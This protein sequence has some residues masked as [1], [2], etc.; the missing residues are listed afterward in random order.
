MRARGWLV[1]ALLLPSLASAQ[2][3]N[4][5]AL[6]ISGPAELV[7]GQSYT[8]EATVRASGPASV[9]WMVYLTQGGVL[10]G[11]VA[12]GPL[13]PSAVS[14]GT[15]TV[16]GQATVP[17]GA[18]GVFQLAVVLDPGQALPEANR[19]DNVFA[20]A[21]LTRVRAPAPNLEVVAVTP[22]VLRAR[23]GDPIT[24]DVE[25]AN[26]G[27]LPGSAAV[28]GYLSRDLQVSTADLAFGVTNV[29][30]AAGGR[31]TVAVSG[32]VAAELP[33]GPR[34]VGAVVDGPQ[35]LPEVSEQDNVGAAAAPLVVYFDTLTLVTADLP[36]GTLHVP[37]SV[38]LNAQGGDGAYAYR[39]ATG[40]LPDGL[41]LVDGVISGT[42]TR[43][44]SF[45]FSLEVSSDGKTDR[46]AFEV[47]VA[48]DVTPLSV[49]TE[50]VT[51]GF[52]NLP[53]EQRLVAG[54]GE[55]PY[56][57]AVVPSGGPLPPGLELTPAGVLTGRPTTLG[58][59]PFTVAVEDRLAHGAERS[60][61]LEVTSATNVII[62]QTPPPPLP[63][64]EPVALTFEAA[65][66][67]PPY[68]WSALSPPPP[69]LSFSAQGQLS[70][71]PSR[72]GRWPIWVRAEDASSG[73]A[74][75]TALLQLEVADTGDFT[76]VTT[77][78]PDA[79]TRLR[80]SVV[81]EATGGA[82]P[83]HWSLAPGSVLPQEFYLVDGDGQQAPLNA[84]YIYGVGFDDDH[85]AFTVRV[86]DAFGRR[87]EMI[88]AF[89][90][91]RVAQEASGGCRCAD[92]PPTSP[93]A[94]FVLVL[95]ALGVSRRRPAG[96]RRS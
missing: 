59:Y 4:V 80:Y 43:S 5:E 23:P 65:G 61:T 92:A 21:E 94:A 90:V 18:A 96:R 88:Y 36:G 29:S 34:T 2:G 45:V 14:A 64:G 93:G 46:R 16:S 58:T 72:V 62:L 30:V 54:G 32:L 27:E 38:P 6:G 60:L 70:G 17:A 8:F 81:L 76:I 31:T 44:G 79:T 95:A 33:A 12:V 82:P 78:L 15:Q 50:A 7:A 87:R 41:T 28:T 11:A 68:R 83:L 40:A 37:Y 9:G 74:F 89:T 75:D 35:A 91:R 77:A 47:A 63:V 53:Y 3:L 26:D 24:V 51:P 1:G 56:T 48:P 42:P 20:A 25:V 85:H 52:L 22:R 55:P 19:F 69:G 66:G 84:G 71:T 39:V 67:T 10:S 86:V 73:P 49:I 13:G 57:W